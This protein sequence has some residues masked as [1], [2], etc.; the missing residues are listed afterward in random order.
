[1]NARLT[2]S[3][4]LALVCVCPLAVG[5]EW[6][7]KMFDT[8]DHDFGSVARG[9]DT[10]FKFKIKNIYK[11]DIHIESVRSSCGC[12]SA[13]IENDTL[14]TYD[15]GYVVA[16]YNTRT[17]TGIHSATLT[18]TIDKPYRAQVQLRV[19]G[20]IR[21]DVVFE[22]GSVVF[23]QVDQGSIA[24]RKVRVRYTGRSGWAIKDV[25]VASDASDNFAVSLDE[26]E[27]VGGRV[28]Y[29]LT[30]RL[31]ESATAGFLKDQLVLVTND[32]RNPRIPLDVEGRIVP[33]ISVAPDNLVFGEIGQG[34]SQ[35]KKIVVR[36]KEPFSITSITGGS[37]HLTFD[38]NSTEAKTTHVVGVTLIAPSEAGR[39]KQEIVVETS[40]GPNFVARCVA[41]ATVESSPVVEP[42]PNV[43]VDDNTDSSTGVIA[44]TNLATGQ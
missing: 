9:S 28:A 24:E 20:N 4:C 41:Y 16:K 18:V 22:P 12:T 26:V 31:T 34:A 29:D 39:F 1:M 37:G 44:P 27:R 13:S 25:V 8:L 11:E 43:T 40:L 14:K 17:F 33:K 6:A 3:L 38:Y 35:T 32:E 42:Q 23:D 21:G 10:V 7:R 2:I 30:V 15:E 36:G 19:H 5:Q